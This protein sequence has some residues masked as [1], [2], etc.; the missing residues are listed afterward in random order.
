M[1]PVNI[2]KLLIQLA[3]LLQLLWLSGWLPD[4][5]AK[6]SQLA[7]LALLFLTL[8]VLRK[9]RRKTRKKPAAKTPVEEDGK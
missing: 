4:Q 8:F 5:A 9:K 3:I 6:G 1:K 7:S 2:A